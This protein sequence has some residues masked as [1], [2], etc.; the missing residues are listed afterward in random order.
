M[1]LNQWDKSLLNKKVGIHLHDAQTSSGF[2]LLNSGYSIRDVL[3][4]IDKNIPQSHR[5]TFCNEVVDL[6]C[7]I[8][9]L[10]TSLLQKFPSKLSTRISIYDDE[11]LTNSDLFALST[12]EW[13]LAILTKVIAQV[14][15]SND[16]P[17]S[18]PNSISKCLVGSIVLLGESD[19]ILFVDFDKICN[20]LMFYFHVQM[21][22]LQIWMK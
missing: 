17:L 22:Q 20:L 11:L 1:E 8:S 4:P 21:M 18:S 10:Q 19:D 14:I 12:S 15:A 16:N 5:D 3:C 7:K 2:A 6:A 9:G 13:S